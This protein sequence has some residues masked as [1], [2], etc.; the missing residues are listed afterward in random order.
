MY[1]LF[2]FPSLCPKMVRDFS[3]RYLSSDTFMSSNGDRLSTF[4][5]RPFES[6]RILFLRRHLSSYSQYPSIRLFSTTQEA[7]ARKLLYDFP[8]DRRKKKATHR[9][10]SH[11]REKYKSRFFR[12]DFSQ[13]TQKKADGSCALPNHRTENNNDDDRELSLRTK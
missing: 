11:P 12:E 7:V 3:P 8:V 4:R 6:S 10:F 2:S 5:N 9:F 1:R 13:E